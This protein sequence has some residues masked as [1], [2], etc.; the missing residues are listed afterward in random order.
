MKRYDLEYFKG[1]NKCDINIKNI[2]SNK[3]VLAM[4]LKHTTE[5][6]ADLPI[7]VIKNCIEGNPVISSIEI[8]PG[9]TFHE[10]IT[11]SAT[12][13]GI[14]NEGVIFFDLVFYAIVPGK[15]PKKIIFNIEAQGNY[16]TKKY[17]ITSRQ[18]YYVSRLIS[19]QKEREFTKSEY[20]DIKEIYSI[21]ICM[22]GPKT[23]QNTVVTHKMSTTIKGIDIAMA[24]SKLRRL[25]PSLTNIVTICLGK[26]TEDKEYSEI[27]D[28][29]NTIVDEDLTLE[30]K[31]N[32]LIKQFEFKMSDS[33][34]K[35]LADMCN[36]S[37]GYV[38]R[39]IEKG[40]EKGLKA[41]VSALKKIYST[42]EDVLNAVRKEEEYKNVT[43]EQVRKYY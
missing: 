27:V 38:E 28:F 25:T 39:G 19:S 36:F 14:P 30:E 24:K 41:L 7:D 17:P 22:N 18:E 8:D 13:N 35:E 10:K 32:K 1:N 9:R 20:G 3:G 31:E 6:F 5:E 37:E 15:R 4:I 40:L 34:R 29:L 23:L 21:W 16:Y 2:L 26:D 43:E 33:F 12:E 11:G 42:F